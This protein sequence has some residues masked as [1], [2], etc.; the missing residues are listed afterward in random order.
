M[1]EQRLYFREFLQLKPSRKKQDLSFLKYHPLKI[2]RYSEALRSGTN[3]E[4]N[5]INYLLQRKK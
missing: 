1:N 5:R 4:I 3:K 2:D